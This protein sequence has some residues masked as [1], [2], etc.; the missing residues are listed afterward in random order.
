[1]K[2][3]PL[4]V[5]IVAMLFID[6]GLTE[7]KNFAPTIIIVLIVAWSTLKIVPQRNV[8]KL[9]ELEVQEKGI[10]AQVELAVATAKI[11]DVLEKVSMD[12]KQATEVIEVAQRVNVN[13]NERLTHAVDELSHSVE[14]LNS[15]MEKVEVETAAASKAGN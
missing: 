14:V 15:R 2:A 4:V 1:M 3:S 9:R 10:A 13:S 11:A 7:L 8:V 6:P 12:Q 5:G